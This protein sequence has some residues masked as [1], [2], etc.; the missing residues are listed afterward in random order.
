MAH[1]RIIFK[2]LL[3]YDYFT[4]TVNGKDNNLSKELMVY[5]IIIL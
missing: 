4:K 2:E 1:I 5:K 3:H